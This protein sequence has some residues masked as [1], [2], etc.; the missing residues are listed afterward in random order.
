MKRVLSLLVLAVI[1]CPVVAQEKEPELSGR[2]KPKLA[3]ATVSPWYVSI[4]G[5][6]EPDNPTEKNKLVFD[7]NRIDCFRTGGI[8]LVGTDSFCIIADATTALRMLSVDINLWKV[9]EWS[10]TEL[11]MVNDSACL[12]SQTTIDLTSK[13]AIALDIK[14][15]D[16]KNFDSCN[17]LPDRQTY[18]LSNRTDYESPMF[19]PLRERR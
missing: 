6:W 7:V 8:D 16:A 11:I 18:Y 17:V 15:P 14:K 1:A 5:A 4:E 19:A 9:V 10:E 12:S 2:G 13:T 3:E